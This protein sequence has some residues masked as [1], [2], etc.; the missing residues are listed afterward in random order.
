VVG[1]LEMVVFWIYF[2]D[3]INSYL[4]IFDMKEMDIAGFWAE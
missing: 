1:E 3:W 2:E 4:P